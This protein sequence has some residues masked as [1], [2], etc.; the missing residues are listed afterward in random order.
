MIPLI[1]QERIHCAAQAIANDA[2]HGQQVSARGAVI[3]ISKLIAILIHGEM[4]RVA[5]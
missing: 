1:E 3:E 5:A 2:T 4:F